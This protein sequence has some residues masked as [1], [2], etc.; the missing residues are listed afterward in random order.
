MDEYFNNEEIVKDYDHVIFKRIISYIKPYRAL[1]AITFLALTVSTIGELM[2]PVFQQRLIDRAILSKYLS[3]NLLALQNAEASLSEEAHKSISFIKNLKDAVRLDDYL[4]VPL[5][6]NMR[7]SGKSEKELRGKNIIEGDSWYVFVNNKEVTEKIKQTVNIITGKNKYAAVKIDDLNNLP[8]DIVKD[9]RKADLNLITRVITLL[10]F[11][12]IFVFFATFVQTWSASLVGQN[13]MKDIRLDLYKKT[14]NQSTDFLSRN[15]VGSIVTRLTGDV[16][17]INEFFTS[18]VVALLKDLSVMSGVLITLF[19]LSPRM[20]CVVLACLPPVIICTAVSRVKARDAFR[21]QRIASSSVTA[22]ISERLS[23]L[24]IVQLFRREDVSKKEFGVRNKELLDANISEIKVF[25]TFRPIVEF[26]ATLTTAAI[27]TVG[28]MLLLNLTLS[29]GVLIAFINLIAMFYA[30]VMD[31][32][33]KY[34]ILQSAM[35][36]GERVFNLLDTTEIIPGN[37]RI[38]T[39][40]EV[41]GN[42]EF[43][44][45]HFSYK[46]G[47]EVLKGLDF[48]VHS[49]EKAAIVGFTG[50][51]KTTV[52]N[53]LSRLW[54]IDKGEIKLDGVNIKDIPLSNLRKIVLPVL[55]DVFL[56]SGTITEN[57][58]LGLNLTEEEIR[59]AA[60]TVQADI[61]IEKLPNGYNTIL[62]EGAT[63]ISGGQRQLLSFARVIAHNP[64]VVVLDEA[65][66]SIDSETERLVQNGIKEVLK[67]RT[68]IVIAH[69]LSTISDADRI[70]VLRAGVLVEQGRHD[71]L[72]KK[73]GLYA[74]LY[75]LQ[76]QKN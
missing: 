45:V 59:A 34:T 32:S 60:R 43:N 37:G 38:E 12:L 33:E 27:I 26:I 74:N 20:T 31:I 3:V 36:G 46:S 13:V 11:A 7:I 15:H 42:I 70:L 4:F 68:S 28:G 58:T 64:A 10:F 17:T 39:G 54:D 2:V 72:I 35:A 71:D 16:E 61:F 69:R 67:G 44:D 63:N 1:V 29:I 25:A 9:I 48:T 55:Q 40:N 50:A 19:V 5:D 76:F 65:T 73:D 23:G 14:L 62:S 49:G 52:V 75:R 47:E 22:Y 30:P 57:I 8:K 21:R 41:K 24:Q 53:V 66:S 51:G 6:Q 56:F 18:F